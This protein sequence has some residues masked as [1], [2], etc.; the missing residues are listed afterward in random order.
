LRTD[1]DAVEAPGAQKHDGRDWL[2]DPDSPR[3]CHCFE[4]LVAGKQHAAPDRSAQILGRVR[5]PL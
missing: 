4:A 2:L 1:L 3:P 5:T